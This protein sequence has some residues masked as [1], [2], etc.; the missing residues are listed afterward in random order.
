MPACGYHVDRVFMLENKFVDLVSRLSRKSEKRE[1]A[2]IDLS[3]DLYNHVEL[4]GRRCAVV[5]V[6]LRSEYY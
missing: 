4:H 1:R 5:G 6:V 3:A 2:S